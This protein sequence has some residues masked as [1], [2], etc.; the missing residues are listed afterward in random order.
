MSQ[1]IVAAVCAILAYVAQMPQG[2]DGSAD[3]A[4]AK[5]CSA[6]RSLQFRPM[7]RGNQRLDWFSKSTVSGK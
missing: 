4:T 5:S 7:R 2:F 3:T 1:D 6:L